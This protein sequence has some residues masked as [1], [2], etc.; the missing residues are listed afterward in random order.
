MAENYN[1]DIPINLNLVA[2]AIRSED[3]SKGATAELDKWI[4][5]LSRTVLEP[6]LTINAKLK[7]GQKPEK[8]LVREFT[9]KLK[10][11][12]NT[13]KVSPELKDSYSKLYD[14]II[15][16]LSTVSKKYD[17]KVREALEGVLGGKS[18]QSFDAETQREVANL[19]ISIRKRVQAI[20]QAL[21]SAGSIYNF[22]APDENGK[23]K[24]LL[25][26]I[27]EDLVRELNKQLETLK[28]FERATN[29]IYAQ[30]EAR[31]DAEL[32]FAKSRAQEWEKLKKQGTQAPEGYDLRG[33]ED[34]YRKLKADARLKRMLTTD[35]AEKAKIQ[36][37]IA[38]YDKE[39]S[40]IGNR[41]RELVGSTLGKS[42]EE[43]TA[44]ST[45]SAKAKRF[46]E[47]K[48][49]EAPMGSL[50]KA[51][52]AARAKSEAQ[53]ALTQA[54]LV[55]QKTDPAS[56]AAARERVDLLTKEKLALDALVSSEEKHYR[57]QL[58][59]T[60]AQKD[61]TQK[62]HDFIR[63]TAKAKVSLEDL[64]KA[65][66]DSSEY[67]LAKQRLQN[68][69]GNVRR[70]GRGLGGDQLTEAQQILAD[71]A[72][73]GV[74]L[75]RKEQTQKTKDRQDRQARIGLNQIELRA[76][77]SE[78]AKQETRARVAKVLPGYRGE[79]SGYA[80]GGLGSFFK[81]MEKDAQGPINAL[82]QLK[83]LREDISASYR[84]AK[85]TGMSS[86]RR[87]LKA[88]EMQL[89]RIIKSYE[90]FDRAANKPAKE[91][92][93]GRPQT[94]GVSDAAVR[95]AERERIRQALISQGDMAFQEVGGLR[96]YARVPKDQYESAKEF[97]LSRQSQIKLQMANVEGDSSLSSRD[98]RRAIKELNLEFIQASRA[99]KYLQSEINGNV[100]PLRQLTLA[101]K[102]FFRYFALYGGA[103]NV[104]GYFQQMTRA[105]VDFQ[106]SLKGTQVIAQATTSEM[107]SIG[108]AVKDVASG[109]GESLQAVSNAAQTLAQAGVDVKNIPS[110]LKAVSD[111][112]LATGS[113]LETASDVIASAKEIFQ[114]DLT[115]GGAAD[116]LTRAVN[117]SKLR[118]ED[119]RTI[120]N[121]GAQTAQGSGLTSAQF[122]GASATLSNIGIKSS[123]VATGLRQ[124][125]LE[126]FNPDEKTMDFLRKRYNQLGEM[127]SDAEIR[128]MYR[129]FQR[130][131][132]PLMSALTELN[133]IGASTT[134]QDDFR[135]VLDIRAE[136]VALPLLKRLDELAKNIARVSETG[137]AAEGAAGRVDSLKKALEQ[138][139]IKL[140]LLV[141]SALGGVFTQIQE[142]AKDLGG[143]VDQIIDY[144][145]RLKINGQDG[146]S[147]VGT[148]A[149]G[150]IA[151]GAVARQFGLGKIGTAI[152]GIA[153]AGAAKVGVDVAEATKGEGVAK[154]IDTAVTGVAAASVLKTVFEKLGP[155]FTKLVQAGTLLA[156]LS[157][158]PIARTALVAMEGVVTV[159]ARFNPWVA[160]AT[161]ATTVYGLVTAL[162]KKSG[163]TTAPNMDA[164]REAISKAN[165]EIGAATDTLK[166]YDPTTKGSVTNQA[167]V[168]LK[169]VSDYQAT[170]EEL[171]GKNADKAK[172]A[173]SVLN[174][175]SLE[176]TPELLDQIKKVLE[177][178][179]SQ[180]ANERGLQKLSKAQ[181][182]LSQA[183]GYIL[184]GQEQ[185]LKKVAGLAGKTGDELSKADKKLLAAY[186]ELRGS[187]LFKPDAFSPEN[188][189]NSLI[190][191]FKFA[192]L[193]VNE[194]TDKLNQAKA[195]AA[196]YLDTIANDTIQKDSTNLLAADARRKSVV[197][198]PTQDGIDA[199]RAE[200]QAWG[201]RAAGIGQQIANDP[202]N[203][204]TYGLDTQRQLALAEQ[205]KSRQALAQ[206]EKALADKTAQEAKA[207]AEQ[208][209]QA[210]RDAAA[211]QK[212]EEDARLALKEEARVMELQITS[213]TEYEKLQNQIVEA[214]KKKEWDRLLAPGGLIDQQYEVQ[215]RRLVAERDLSAMKLRN[216]ANEQGITLPEKLTSIS[217]S[218]RESLITKPETRSLVE[219]FDTRVK[220][221]DTAYSEYL[222]NRAQAKTDRSQIVPYSRSADAESRMNK[223]QDAE[224]R[225]LTV[226][227]KGG[228]EYL[229]L[230]EEI[231]Q[232]KLSNLQEELT[233]VKGQKEAYDAQ[234]PGRHSAAVDRVE[235]EIRAE[236]RRYSRLVDQ[237]NDQ[238][239]RL[240]L[241]N[242]IKTL[243]EEVKRLEDIRNQA[244][245]GPNS[246]RSASWIVKGGVPM[247]TGSGRAS[248]YDPLFA[249]YEQQYPMI[250]PGLMK[251]M[252][253]VESN[254]NPTAVSSK[255]ARGL[256]QLMPD[257]ARRVGVTDL[258]DPEQSIMGAAKNL[259][260]LIQYFKGDVEKVIA[261]YNTSFKNVDAGKLPAETRDYKQK[262]MA[263]WKRGGTTAAT[264]QGGLVTVDQTSSRIDELLALRQDL[265]TQ[266]NRLDGGGT[267]G[268]QAVNEETRRRLA[269]NAAKQQQSELDYLRGQVQ[270]AR[271]Q[272]DTQ[273]AYG[274]PTGPSDTAARESAGILASPAM[275]FERLNRITG[276]LEAL[277][278]AAEASYTDAR[279]AEQKVRDSIAELE[280]RLK[281]PNV[282]DKVRQDIEAEIA[283]KKENLKAYEA[284]IIEFRRE[285][286]T[287]NRELANNQQAKQ[288]Y[289]PT[290]T[291][292]SIQTTQFDSQGNIVK[293]TAQT[294]GQLDQVNIQNLTGE[295][296]NLSYAFNKLG[297]NINKFIVDVID[298]FVDKVSRSIIDS[299]TGASNA[300]RAQANAEYQSAVSNAQFDAAVRNEQIRTLKANSNPNAP[301]YSAEAVR[302]QQQNIDQAYQAS[303]A[304]N[305]AQ[306]EA[307]AQAKAEQDAQ[308]GLSGAL[309][310]LANEFSVTLMKTAIMTPIEGVLNGLF[311]KADGS[312]SNPLYVWVKNPGFEGKGNGAD[313]VAGVAESA[314]SGDWMGSIKSAM[315]SFSDDIV[316]FFTG[317]GDFFSQ[318]LQKGGWL[319]T[320][321]SV[322]G[323][324]F[325]GFFADGGFV[326]GPG[327][328]TSD[329]IPAWLSNG[330]YVLTAAEVQRIGVSNLNKWKRAM[331]APAKFASGGLVGTFDT[332]RSALANSDSLQGNSTMINVIDQRSLQNSEPVEVKKSKVGDKE[333]IDIMVKDA[334]KKAINNGA[335][336]RTMQSTYGVRRTGA[337]R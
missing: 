152:S 145:N 209:A 272:L 236:D 91:Q 172:E 81:L 337:M 263:A 40:S 5:A 203:A 330:E 156:G 38:E 4:Q 318:G 86:E 252:A 282:T 100:G 200:M 51:T 174:G 126:L 323:G 18:L 123:T 280:A 74:T 90:D 193:N 322:V 144:R 179:W 102:A 320:A 311:G 146:V 98:K 205:D 177:P 169:A 244:S 103:Y 304:A 64:S 111:F 325:G 231:H 15:A 225:L 104:I 96:N 183:R 21:T 154:A 235:N 115:F 84:E 168:A 249:K 52:Y 56:E 53:R 153:G 17:P 327:T 228:E 275:E 237:A 243:D 219:D 317:I 316:N 224:D 336:D 283:Q 75:R 16:A 332:A 201:A 301:G 28:Q 131:D 35:L 122:L 93:P 136:N 121:L 30:R 269:E 276:Y 230:A 319:D 106:D 77:L 176:S 50:E 12:L 296:N 14:D 279:V 313:G 160:A 255:G 31:K 46:Y 147:S 189:V 151:A 268:Q 159:L 118:A 44:A 9:E 94:T 308:S 107:I 155:L 299:I 173:L 2:K 310:T 285:I 135:R 82:S 87:E 68:D 289:N 305:R 142:W 286:E 254:F 184:A 221:L 42:V 216:A 39:L 72:A 226:Q 253:S 178:L 124:L 79:V 229:K 321:F 36:A 288:V 112:A 220:N 213:E 188:M 71:A 6:E 214:K 232:L 29:V 190:D 27:N 335:L 256:M 245:T 133:R 95:R 57:N 65:T 273:V 222:K 261:G 83:L 61:Q 248:A 295:L 120:Y 271:Q 328:G 128:N 23:R 217:L 258:N 25:P 334:V 49:M 208:V 267:D 78:Q 262:V 277:T 250:P 97:A 300:A 143:V 167:N 199:L 92:R 278:A 47:S 291:G 251:A 270:N 302:N 130:T 196:Q 22:G 264:D 34:A 170:L 265:K 297:K 257:T 239:K 161:L 54:N 314:A 274:L 73:L 309:S 287:A 303:Q 137:A 284:S 163:E 331:A 62:Q 19:K 247:A 138:L 114:G 158:G 132:N 215:K 45:R 198:N 116:Q 85:L 67:F 60:E 294:Y 99:A 202:R 66:K 292:E 59:G 185:I 175:A 89:G 105:L 326:R 1:A 108:Q 260:W 149:A 157:S 187:S 109:S 246:I 69:L 312:Q 127:R 197:A 43:A 10:L 211:R 298:T 290:L 223:I 110:A 191:L 58:Q 41:R 165:Q 148:A 76:A 33:T 242:Q 140:E 207:K 293:G 139:N 233:H 234:G 70:L 80:S 117:I 32:E 180:P 241:K 210:E 204:N 164:V 134:A 186:E 20:Q 266:L 125:L 3:L 315:S 240:D 88:L 259:K 150:A 166:G 26:V 181:S 101:S 212:A 307:A 37:Q 24:R 218:Q 192:N 182:E 333:M 113:S 55:L 281:D 48:F 119:L 11:E 13:S 8:L 194:A 329:S 195:N 63:E 141:N 238:R 206:A 227:E 162:Q 324:L 7:K 306:M 129:G 171:F